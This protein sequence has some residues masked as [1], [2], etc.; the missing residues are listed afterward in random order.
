[1]IEFG[2]FIRSLSV[3]HPKARVEDKVQFAFKLYD[4]RQTGYIER[5]EVKAMLDA[6]LCESTMNLTEEIMETILDMTFAE[7]QTKI[8]GRID[9]EE[10]ERLVMRHPS[11][12]QNMNLPYL[13]DINT[14][15]PSF[16][17]LNDTDST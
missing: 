9:L 17:F 8:E 13:K 10:W 1:M 5:E 11:L 16:S 7:A 6:L 14:T 15:F 2:E 3:F 12:L 4:L